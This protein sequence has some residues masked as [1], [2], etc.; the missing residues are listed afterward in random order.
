MKFYFA[1]R[2][3]KCLVCHLDIKKGELYIR[4]THKGTDGHWYSFSH[5]YECYITAFTERVRQDALYYMGKLP[6]PK[7]PGKPQ[8]HYNPKEVN[9]LKSLIRYHVNKGN[10]ELANIAKAKLEKELQND[11]RNTQGA[12]VG[13]R[14]G[15]GEVND[16][17]E[18]AASSN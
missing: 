14:T 10:T 8:I 9:R 7:K 3:M 5:H 4:N 6:R 12:E 13:I 17:A 16:G 15:G 1:K 2:P 11:N 18:E